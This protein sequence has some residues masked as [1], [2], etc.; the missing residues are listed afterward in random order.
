MKRRRILLVSSATR[1][2][3]LSGFHHLMLRAQVLIRLILETTSWSSNT[4]MTDSSLMFL[5]IHILLTQSSMMVILW[6][7]T[8]DQL[9]DIL[10][11]WS[12]GRISKSSTLVRPSVSLMVPIGW[13][14]Q[15]LIRTKWRVI[16]HLSTVTDYLRL[17]KKHIISTT[18]QF[19]WTVIT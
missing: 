13:T 2:S 7:H 18:Y 15:L 8:A 4:K 3:V 1:K 10:K 6:I 5:P 12:V 14:P 16:R 17:G 11:F 19:P 9:K